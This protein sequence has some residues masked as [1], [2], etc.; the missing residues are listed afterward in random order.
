M[1]LAMAMVLG[2][3]LTTFAAP[4]D[5]PDPLTTTITV[6]GDKVTATTEA[7]LVPILVPVYD[8]S[9]YKGWDFASGVTED[10]V[11][12][13]VEDIVDAADATVVNGINEGL[14]SLTLSSLTPE[15][16]YVGATKVGNN[17]TV[18]FE[19]VTAGLY[20]IKARDAANVYEYSWMV[21]NVNYTSTDG[22]AGLSPVTVTAK[23]SSNQ[24]EKTVEAKNQSVSEGDQVEYTV[25]AHYPVFATDSTARVFEISDEITGG[26]I[27]AGTLKVNDVAVT[28]TP[29]DTYG[30]TAEV[31]ENTFTLSLKAATD[32]K[33][34]QADA[35]LTITYT[36]EVGEV[37]SEA[38]LSN[39]V[40]TNINGQTRQA[41]VITPSAKVEIT[42][43]DESGETITATEA[44]FQLYVKYEEG[45]NGTRATVKTSSGDE[46]EVLPV[47]DP[48]DTVSGIATFDGLDAQKTYYVK[49]TK[50]PEG[51]AVDEYAHELVSV[52][53]IS[54]TTAPASEEE[55][56][57]VPTMVT[58]YTVPDYTQVTGFAVE[59]N[60]LNFIDQTLASLPSTGGIGTTIFTI[61]GCAIMIIAA[62]LYFS[63]RRKNVK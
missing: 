33:P 1:L 26:T 31:G 12:M 29:D 36:V 32:Y 56:D 41:V 46:V 21:A 4:G 28:T 42:K 47:G 34:A 37:T 44:A 58:T 3:S 61:G 27:V 23:G 11:G 8:G 19:D 17:Y 59:N 10:I 52:G 35:E 48:V 9:G 50:A 63:L 5:E 60:G 30:L 62:G 53:E 16:G 20:A 2:M 13:S 55:Y 45:M 25:T 51:F 40:S 24:P 54:S 57:G 18:V 7:A 6:G 49:E 38:P 14:S 39:K 43:T 15:S 22:V